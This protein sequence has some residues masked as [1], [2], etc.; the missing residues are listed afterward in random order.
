MRYTF[1]VL[2]LASPALSHSASLPHG[3]SADWV[4]LVA[5]MLIGAAAL[6]AKRK[7]VQVRGRQ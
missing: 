1:P 3:H 6:M 2:F 5:L 4:V 7:A